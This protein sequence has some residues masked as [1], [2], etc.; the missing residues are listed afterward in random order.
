MRF[1]IIL[2]VVISCNASAQTAINEK[3]DLII[4]MESNP[5]LDSATLAEDTRRRSTPS[6]TE[7]GVRILEFP[8][9]PVEY[10]QGL[11]KLEENLASTL[12][13]ERRKT[14][15]SILKRHGGAVRIE[16]YVEASGKVTDIEFTASFS[17]AIQSNLE[18]IL[19]EGNWEVGEYMGDKF[20]FKCRLELRLKPSNEN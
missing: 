4:K 19:K 15:K 12:N 11:K 7:N 10:T 9:F 6:F 16:F 2:L 14:V 13:E 3:F 8:N 5:D 1:L 18:Q 20:R 17:K